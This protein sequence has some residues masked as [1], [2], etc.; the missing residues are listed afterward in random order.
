[1]TPSRFADLG[2]LL[3]TFVMFWAYI[4]LSQ[5]LLIWY[6]NIGEETT[7]YLNRLQGAWQVVALLLILLHFVLPAWRFHSA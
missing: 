3:M 4:A 5:F 6:G 2:G 1:M 7:W